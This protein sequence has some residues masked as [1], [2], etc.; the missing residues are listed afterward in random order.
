MTRPHNVGIAEHVMLLSEETLATLSFFSFENF[1][2]GPGLQSAG[3]PPSILFCS[4]VLG[5]LSLAAYLKL[6]LHGYIFS[7]LHVFYT[8]PCFFVKLLEGH[9]AICHSSQQHT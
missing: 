5:T 6:F 1:V 2:G 4:V 9:P 8:P 3:N 7:M